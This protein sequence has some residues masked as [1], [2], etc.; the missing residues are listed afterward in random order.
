[1]YVFAICPSYL[2]F[3]SARPCLVIP[4]A[5]TVLWSPRVLG[6]RGLPSLPEVPACQDQKVQGSLSL[7]LHL[8]YLFNKYI[9]ICTTQTDS[10]IK[11]INNFTVWK[12]DILFGMFGFYVCAHHVVRALQVVPVIQ[13]FQLSLFLVHL[14]S[15]PVQ[16]ALG[17]PRHL[18]LKTKGRL[19]SAWYW[20]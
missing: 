14:V 8:C 7:P 3:R 5:L 2:G 19:Y 17:V 9:G 13:A 15:Q 18:I 20:R 1:M 4:F 6:I 11:K 16:K 10:Q 12:T